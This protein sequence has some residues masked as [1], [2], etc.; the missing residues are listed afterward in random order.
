MFLIVLLLASTPHAEDLVLLRRAQAD[1]DRVAAAASPRLNDVIACKQSQAAAAPVA[2]PA[3]L[4]LSHF[5]KGYCMLL[6]SVLS[7]DAA[8]ARQ[9]AGEFEKSEATW[10]VALRGPA[11]AFLHAMAAVAELKGNP[12]AKD[13]RKLDSRLAEGSG[14]SSCAPGLMPAAQCAPLLE[15]AH[16]WRG[17]IAVNQHELGKAAAIL[18][19]LPASGWSAWVAGR[20]QMEA[21]NYPEAAARFG[22]TLASWIAADKNPQPPAIDLL[23]PALDIGGAQQSLAESQYLSGQYA[24]AVASLEASLQRRPRNPAA[25]FLRGRARQALGQSHAAL[26]DYD[27]ASRMALATAEPSSPS[28]PA[29]FYRGVWF[30]EQHQYEQAEQEFAIALS[31]ALDTSLKADVTAWWRM[32]AVGDGACQTSARLLESSLSSVS[33]YFPKH[34]ARDLLGACRTY[35]EKPKSVTVLQYGIRQ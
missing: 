18:Q 32:A 14:E 11:P 17:W 33:D 34:Q 2:P 22:E 15:A 9:A 3:E 21:R 4:P 5:R 8:E 31:A 25:I 29:H 28:G 7:R 13:F 27:L 10:P 26:V 12:E 30:F 16:I 35:S 1:F 23:K 19:P 24:A 6:E 20:R